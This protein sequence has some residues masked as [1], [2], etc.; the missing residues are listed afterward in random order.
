MIDYI[1][2]D[3]L[4]FPIDCRLQKIKSVQPHFHNDCVVLMFILKGEFEVHSANLHKTTEAGDLIFINSGEVHYTSGGIE[5]EVLVA[6]MKIGNNETFSRRNIY[7][8]EIMNSLKLH[9]LAL[10]Y[11]K[12]MEEMVEELDYMNL[13]RKTCE[14]IKTL[15]LLDTD[16]CQ[17]VHAKEVYCYICKKYYKNITA[18]KVAE[19]FSISTKHLLTLIRCCGAESFSE[20][21][22]Y[23]RCREA[24]KLLLETDFKIQTI[25]Q[26]CGFLSMSMFIKKYKIFSGN[27]PL[28]QRKHYKE[29][30][31]HIFNRVR[32]YPQY[33]TTENIIK[34]LGELCIE[35]IKSRLVW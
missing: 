9:L 1:T 27:T 20:L 35:Y 10:T 2:L 12:N 19:Y 25:A 14:L 34:Y 28:Q 33:Y 5:N 11:L 15:F 21:L 24:D 32:D 6:H 7:D 4:S 30:S 17:K 31:K 26:K 22:S 13:C 23:I 8:E 16:K 3:E 18:E 29:R